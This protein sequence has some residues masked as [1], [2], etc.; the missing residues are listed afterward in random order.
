MQAARGACGKNS[1]ESNAAMIQG[2]LVVVM[3]ITTKTTKD[4]E[5]NNKKNE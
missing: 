1:S 3:W 5:N 4:F 2:L